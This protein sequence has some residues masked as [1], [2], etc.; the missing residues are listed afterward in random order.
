MVDAEMDGQSEAQTEAGLE[1]VTVGGTTQQSG[2]HRDTH[3]VPVENIGQV[4]S[5]QLYIR[6]Q[7]RPRPANSHLASGDCFKLEVPAAALYC[8]GFLCPEDAHPVPTRLVL[9]LT[10]K[11]SQ[12]ESERLGR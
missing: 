7:L 12:A 6:P 8:I 3:A 9:C 1:R 11:R 4:I 5:S 10:Y 2:V